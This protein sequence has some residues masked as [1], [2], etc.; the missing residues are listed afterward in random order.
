[1][2]FQSMKQIEKQNDVNDDEIDLKI[3][4]QTS[5]IPRN[6]KLKSAKTNR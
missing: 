6:L 1:M 3:K 5:I 4:I 2:C